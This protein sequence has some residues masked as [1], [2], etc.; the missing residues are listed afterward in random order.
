MFY[1][2]VINIAIYSIGYCTLQC[3]VLKGS[4]IIYLPGG[5]ADS[6]AGAEKSRRDLGGQKKFIFFHLMNWMIRTVLK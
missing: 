1:I 2:L 4:F 6:G 3:T 5:A